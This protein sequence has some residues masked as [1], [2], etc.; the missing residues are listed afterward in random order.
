MCHLVIS[1]G[2][3][4]SRLGAASRRSE[5]W[6]DWAEA[7]IRAAACFRHEEDTTEELTAQIVG[8]FT[9]GIAKADR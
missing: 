1:A 9:H 8:I 5:T 3:T 7:R 2:S 4:S 6:I